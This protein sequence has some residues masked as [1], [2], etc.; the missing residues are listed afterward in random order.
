M[1]F[2]S[3]IYEDNFE[4][5]SKSWRYQNFTGGTFLNQILNTWKSYSYPSLHTIILLSGIFLG[6]FSVDVYVLVTLT[7]VWL[8]IANHH[9]F[10]DIASGALISYSIMLFNNQVLL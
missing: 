4:F 10:S 7:V 3:Y 1:L 2:R 9:W 6:V 8:I 5:S